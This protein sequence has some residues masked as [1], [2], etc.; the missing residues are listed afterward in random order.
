MLPRSANGRQYQLMVQLPGSYATNANARYPVIYVLDGYWDFKLLASIVGGLVHDKFMPEAIIV[1]IG[2]PDEGGKAPDYGK[3]R[4][5]RP[6][7]GAGH[8]ARTA[9]TRARPA[10]RASSWT[11]L[12]RDQ[13]IPFVESAI[14]PMPVYRVLA[15]S[16]YG[17]LF[18]LHVLFTRPS[19]FAAYICPAH[20][21]PSRSGWLFD[22]EEQF[23]KS[24][25]KLSARLYMTAAREECAICRRPDQELDARCCASAHTP[26]WRTSSASRRRA[27]LRHQARELQPRRSLRVRAARP[28]ARPVTAVVLDLVAVGARPRH[29]VQAFE[30]DRIAR[31]LADAVAAVFDLAQRVVHVAQQLAVM[32]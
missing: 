17:G 11:S 10:T 15:G 4:I 8:A 31:R 13:F 12:D 3:L 5:L 19:L 6:D 16:R 28:F 21:P 23:A 14:A 9:R 1:G 29:G 20:R 30:R 25:T 18:A 26:A 32:L 2:Y 22:L 24:G 7:A 27:P